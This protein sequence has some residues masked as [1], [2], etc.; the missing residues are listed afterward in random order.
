[1]T[2]ARMEWLLETIQIFHP[3]LTR[4]HGH[5]G[6]KDGLFLIY[7]LALNIRPKTM[8]SRR[9]MAVGIL[10]SLDTAPRK[11]V[12]RSATENGVHGRLLNVIK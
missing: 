2:L 12:G 11:T 8:T 5:L 6:T 3:T 7:C 4:F 9:I 10:K 1:M